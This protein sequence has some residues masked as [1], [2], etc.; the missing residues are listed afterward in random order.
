MLMFT[1][2]SQNVCAL[3]MTDLNRSISSC[4]SWGL[5]T[6]INQTL[7]HVCMCACVHARARVCVCVCVGARVRVCVCVCVC[8]HACTHVCKL[9]PCVTRPRPVTYWLKCCK[10]I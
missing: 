8:V 3:N 6:T 2:S 1:E 4:L 10:G 7:T 9:A 5:S